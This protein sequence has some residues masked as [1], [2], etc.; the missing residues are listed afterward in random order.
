MS[1]PSRLTRLAAGTV[2]ATRLVDRL[3]GKFDVLRSRLILR[4]GTDA[5]YSAF[6]D[7]TYGGQR[8][9]QPGSPAFRTEL[10]PWEQPRHRRALSET[11]GHGAD[12][13][14]RWWS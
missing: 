2:W 8:A 6:N 10:F 4:H 7:V 5:F 1:K 12:W 13:G 11:T 3:Y 9:Y 14:R